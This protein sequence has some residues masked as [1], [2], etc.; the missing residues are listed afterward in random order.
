LDPKD[1][2]KVT[3]LDRKQFCNF[4]LDEY[5]TVFGWTPEQYGWEHLKMSDAVFDK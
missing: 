1:V 4:K 2:E 3:A 5:G